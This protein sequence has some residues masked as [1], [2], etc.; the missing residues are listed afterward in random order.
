MMESNALFAKLK[1]LTKKE[2]LF[3]LERVCSRGHRSE[4]EY[5]LQILE[6][7]KEEEVCDLMD[8]I[9]EKIKAL[10][11]ERNLLLEPYALK[12]I[13]EVPMEVLIEAATI[14][15]Q[16]EIEHNKFIKLI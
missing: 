7:K 1:K 4:V 6:Q 9:N 3:V 10:Q 2:L 16:I 5:A 13:T 8:A 12:K 11:K 15:K 14:N